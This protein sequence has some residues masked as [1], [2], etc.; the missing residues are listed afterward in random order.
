MK[1]VLHLIHTTGPGGAETIFM[2]LARSLEGG[3]WKSHV[4]VTGEGWL[5]DALRETGFEPIVLPNSDRRAYLRGLVR[6]IRSLGVDLVQAH[7]LGPSFYASLAGILCGVPVIST[8]HGACDVNPRVSLRE[9]LR[10]GLICRGSRKIVLVSDSLR[11]ELLGR[12]YAAPED[13]AVIANGIDTAVFRPRADP[14]FRRDLGLADHQILVGAVGN[15]RAP[16]D[17]P[18]FLRSAALLAERSP[19]YRFVI[20]GENQGPR[21]EELLRLRAELGLGERVAFAGFRPDVHRVLNSLDVFVVSSRT[22]GFS[23]AAVQAMA[24]GVPVVATRCGGPEEILTDGR[25]GLL[26]EVGSPEQIAGA[27]DRLRTEPGLRERLTRTAL[28][29]VE[30]SYSIVEMLRRYEELYRWAVSGW[31]QGRTPFRVRGEAGRELVAI[32][33]GASPPGE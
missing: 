21:Y 3:D 6:I 10:Y 1:T 24:S 9:R 14:S 28:Q 23:L 17:Y 29:R 15:V 27:V 25:D 33:G 7:L 20:V 11:Q 13:T 5:T 8:Y 16:K 32:P 19:D 30:E 26:V 2:Q 4:C 12:G 31:K 18:T 22:E